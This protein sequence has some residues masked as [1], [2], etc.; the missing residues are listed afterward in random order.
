MTR[1]GRSL[2][3]MGLAA[4]ALGSAWLALPRA[5]ATNAAF[6]PEVTPAPRL[7]VLRVY[8][9]GPADV[10]RLA[11]SGWDVLETRGPDYLL[12]IGDDV[13]IRQLRAQGFEV[14]I[15][16]AL[17]TAAAIR[18]FSYYGGYRTVAE[19]YQH[20]DD[21]AAARPDLAV[22]VDY[23]DSW[24]KAN[25]RPDGHDLKAICITRLRA[26]DCALDPETDKPRFLLIAAI[27]ARELST[28]EL[29]WRWMDTLVDND[30]VDP[31]VTAL[32][33]YS[34]MWIIPIANPDGRRIV[35][36]GG[37]S[38]YLQRK[39]ANTSL[40]Y[41]SD[42]PTASN[43]YGVD[44]NRNADFQYGVAG[45][46]ADPCAQTYRGAQAASEPE[47]DAL[48][49]LMR[50]LFRDQRGAAITD[51]APLTTSGAMLT[52]HSYGDLVL[53]PW[54]WTECFGF[55][56]TAGKQAPNDAGLRSFAFR[57]S[58]YN[59]YNTGQASELL[60]AAS[61]T[62]DDWAY[63]VLGIPGFTFEVGPQFFLFECSGFTP[64][65]A[66][67]DGTF[68]PAQRGAFLYAARAARRPYADTSG[69]TTLSVSL[70]ITR[71]AAGWPVT[72]TAVVDDNAYGGNGV[73]RPAAQPIN[74]AEYTVDAPPWAGGAPIAMAALDGTFDTSA[75]T[76]VAQVDTALSAGRH[77]LFVRGRDAAGNWGPVTAQ[78][79]FVRYD[80]NVYLPLV[81]RQGE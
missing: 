24:R 76:A 67:Q 55:P 4:L 46:S 2:L 22:V 26:G 61:G 18:P 1:S 72:L 81:M 53:L 48:E 57:M 10:A 27:H 59:R 75:E 64:P 52:L 5:A 8:V 39:N 37:N 19:H 45:T 54:G 7:Y 78:W 69:P 13:V 80:S 73:G 28:A 14:V 50:S 9:R 35:E 77:T 71:T 16:H 3:V 23:G 21:L 33:E 15:D 20:M 43:H 25:N 47:E 38:P 62:T 42:P 60:Y 49:N 41:C 66:C 44:L 40:G 58:Y 30:D 31:D 11:S 32:L 34:E 65:Y 74:A 68:W 79:L 63:G 51:T 56:C 6:D 36:Q 12:V 29:A 17:E 70:S